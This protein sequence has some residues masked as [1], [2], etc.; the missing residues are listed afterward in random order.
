M[1]R[2]LVAG[3]WKLHKTI[4]E[5]LALVEELKAGV[6]GA[7]AAEVVVAPVFTALAAVGEALRGSAIS[8]A[9]QNC[10]PEAKGAF[11]GEVSPALLRDAG[12]SYVIVGHS[13]RRRIFR[14]SDAFISRKVKAVIAE[15]MQAILCV[16][17][18]LEERND[19]KTFQILAD[20]IREGLAGIPA[21]GMSRVVIAYEPVWAIGT[22]KNAT[23]DQ[24]QEVHRFLRNLLEEMYGG[25]TAA[26]LRILY[27]GS[28]KGDN[29]AELLGQED[30]DGAL[31]GGAS[32]KAADF[33]SIVKAGEK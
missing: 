4:A 19:D 18:T 3:N 27:G 25:A 32:L 10:Y 14:E 1:R 24:A 2:T 33:L 6:D 20:Q 9:A 21:E 11:T 17:E 22:G 28:V 5:A 15:E 16:G 12:C 29:A 31:V 13:E 8:L 7:T 23:P 26:H 30:I